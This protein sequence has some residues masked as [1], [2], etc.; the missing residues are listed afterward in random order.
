MEVLLERRVDGRHLVALATDRRDG[1]VHPRRVPPI[2][3]EQRQRALAGQRWAMADQVH[4]TAVVSVDT[5]PAAWP[6]AG[7]GDVLAVAPT[8]VNSGPMPIAVWAA[9]CAAVALFGAGGSIVMFH[10]GWR[11]LAAGVVDVAIDAMAARADAVVAAVLGPVIHPCCYEFGEADV[12]AVAA[13]VHADIAAVTGATSSGARALDVPRAIRFGLAGRGVALD[14]TGPCTGCSDRW[15][16]HRVHA[17]GGRHAV[18]AW[19]SA[20]DVAR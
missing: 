17:D 2:E 20:S 12:A 14:V 18:V 15:F 13:G 9:D 3:L 8:D 19:A 10:A 7:R 11:G 5:A 1:D 16:S 4:G 6:L